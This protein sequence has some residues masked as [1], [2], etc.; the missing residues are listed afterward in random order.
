VQPLLNDGY[1]AAKAVLLALCAALGR[2]TSTRFL[3][4]SN[5]QSRDIDS[6]ADYLSGIGKP[7][8]CAATAT[9]EDLINVTCLP[10]KAASEAHDLTTATPILAAKSK[11]TG[12]ADILLI[13]AGDSLVLSAKAVEKWADDYAITIPFGIAGDDPTPEQRAAGIRWVLRLEKGFEM[14]HSIDDFD[15]S[16]QMKDIIGEEFERVRRRSE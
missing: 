8:S 13:G 16:P 10:G 11:T 5:E 12:G 14:S 4:G 6:A 3:I 7:L 2:E 1:L 9:T 15:F